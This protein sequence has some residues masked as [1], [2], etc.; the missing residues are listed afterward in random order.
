MRAAVDAAIEAQRH[1]AAVQGLNSRSE[2]FPCEVQGE[3]LRRTRPSANRSPLNSAPPPAPV[4]ATPLRL[5]RHQREGVRWLLA[6]HELHL[7]GIVADEMGL[8]KTVQVISFFAALAT[9]GV[10]GTYLIVAPL[11][12]LDNWA[13]ELRR[14][15]PWVHVTEFRGPHEARASL[16]AR[17]RKRH[18]RAFERQDTLRAQ[19]GSGVPVKELAQLVGGVV[20][21]SYES[22]MM[23]HAALARLLC[24]DVLVVDEAHRLKKLDCKL[25]RSLNKASCGMRLIL[26]GTPLQNDLA[27]L[28]TLLEYV[29]PHLF[30]HDDDNQRTLRA[31]VSELPGAVSASVGAS[32]ASSD[33]MPAALWRVDLLAHLRT[34]LRPFLLRRTK[35]DAGVHLPPKYD[36]LLPTPLTPLQQAFYARVG[37]AAKYGNSRL[38]H[39]RKCCIHPFLFP[40]FREATFA[41]LS[42]TSGRICVRERLACMLSVSGKLRVLDGMLPELR[43]RGHRV[44]LFSQMT[45]ALDL[46]EEY[47]QLKNAVIEESYFSSLSAGRLSA[48]SHSAQGEEV[49]GSLSGLVNRMLVYTRLD[50]ASPSDVRIEAIRRF[51]SLSSSAPA[52]GDAM[53]NAHATSAL[54]AAGERDDE[55]A[56]EALLPRDGAAE[57][58]LDRTSPFAATRKRPRSACPRDCWMQ[59]VAEDDAIFDAGPAGAVPDVL[60]ER[61]ANRLPAR[62]FKPT[63]ATKV[64]YAKL[65]NATPPAASAADTHTVNNSP[66]EPSSSVSTLS[67]TP[68]AADSVEAQSPA[69]AGTEPFLCL[70]STRAGGTGLNLTGADTVILLDGDFNPHNDAQAVDRCHRI[71]QQRPVAIYRLVTPRTVEDAPH[72]G[73]V[74]RKRKLEQMMLGSNASVTASRGARDI[75]TVGSIS[76]DTA[77]ADSALRVV[78]AREVLQPK[79]ARSEMQAL[80]LDELTEEHLRRLLDRQWLQEHLTQG[81]GC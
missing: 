46:V 30:S 31:A 76:T 77:P 80:L 60:Q 59:G 40:E 34:A 39:L 7:H 68:C 10:L 44:L 48:C 63:G 24:W 52:D 15:L 49:A 26:T 16:R 17:L 5:L 19:W 22:V 13:R 78:D 75:K 28:W 58:E 81:N 62:A 72:Q 25:L 70:I 69:T 8:G 71:G 6:L 51:Q 18:R 2:F 9:R 37:E 61:P 38:S 55:D 79:L 47:L 53:G 74:A 41:A 21:A 29:A 42:S 66:K 14:W 3:A 73:I 64:C 23:E 50:G 4:P 12:T 57:R 43:R 33:E 1:A 11:S 54:T 67:Q 45:K 27:E 56:V 65:V 20:L 32:A 35:A 36:I